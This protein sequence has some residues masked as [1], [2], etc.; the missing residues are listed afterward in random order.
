LRARRGV[1]PLAFV[2]IYAVAVV[3]APL[4]YLAYYAYHSSLDR[5]MIEVLKASLEQSLMQA[6]LST[7]ISLSVGLLFGL[8]LIVYNGKMKNIFISLLLV[9]YVMPGIVMA[10]GIIS[11]FGY[12]SRFWE[13]IYGNVVY[14]APMISVLAFSTGNSANL[15]EIY[16]AKTLGAKDSEIISKF[17]LPSSLR[18]GMLGAILTFILSFEGFSLPLIIGGPSYST[19]EV[20]IYELK[21]ILPTISQVP[22]SGASLLGLIQIAILIVPLYAY[23]TI[24]SRSRRDDSNLPPPLKRYNVVALVGLVLFIFFISVPFF[25]MFVKYPIWLL[26]LHSVTSKLQISFSALI[27]NTVLFSFAS[28]F[29]AFMISIII[30][31]YRPTLRNQFL[32]LLPLIFSPVTLALSYFLIYGEHIPTSILIILIF[33]AIIIPLNLRMMIQSTGTIMPSESNS[34]RIL[35]DS[36]FATFFKVQLPRIKWEMSTILS[37][38]FITVMGEFSSIVTVYT[39]STETITIGIYNLLY[40]RDLRDTYNLTEIFLIVI[41]ISSLIINHLGKSGSVGQT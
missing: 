17:Y 10:I 35:G 22:F 40:L 12:S 30:T 2:S 11:I 20:M 34:S 36:P 6:T 8:L 19:M 29:I 13:I 18:G 26:D 14:N 37:L 7:I 9:T 24:R 41:F 16:S 15:R 38:M 23:L 3:I 32:I 28:T 31:V 5:L 21:S 27:S 4:L 33:A 25:G 1:L 39:Q